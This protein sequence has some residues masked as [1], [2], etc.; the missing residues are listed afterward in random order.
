MEIASQ[1]Y[2]DIIE[3]NVRQIKTELVRIASKYLIEYEGSIC[4][5][6]C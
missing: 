3:N 5:T 1:L 2:T 6:D 4:G